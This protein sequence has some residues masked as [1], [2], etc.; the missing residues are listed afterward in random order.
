MIRILYVLW[1]G[2]AVVFLSWP[3]QAEAQI[4]VTAN[5]PR[6]ESLSQQTVSV[7]FTTTLQA[8]PLPSVIGWSVRVNTIPVTV[9]S[10][11]ILGRRANIT[12][13]ATPAHAANA[14]LIPGDVVDISY[15]D[16]IA[17][18]NTLTSASVEIGSFTNVASKNNWV[19]ACSDLAF[20]L[21]GNYAQP[22]ICSPVN[23]NFKQYQYY[24]S[25]RLRNS[26]AFTL[27]A[28]FR[29]NILWGDGTPGGSNAGYYSD[30]AGTAD[31]A[32]YSVTPGFP[33]SIATTRAT[34]VF[35][36]NTNVCSFTTTIFPFIVGVVNCNTGLL[37]QQTTFIS[38]DFDSENTGA[39]GLVPAVANSNRICLGNNVNMRFSD[40]TNLNC[41]PDVPNIGAPNNLIRWIRVVYGYQNNAGGAINNIRNVVVTGLLTGGSINV[42]NAA[43][44]ISPAGGYFPTGGGGPGIPNIPDG[45]GVIELSTPVTVATA[46]SFMQ[47]ITT[48]A[49]TGHAVGQR[50]Y[51]RLDYWNTCNQ[52]D[53]TAGS[54]ALART[55]D[56]YDEIITKP[57][58]L[59][60]AGQ[61]LC[62]T[63]PNSTAF[64]FTGA[65][66]IGAA[67]TGVNWY[68]DVASVATATRMT[69]GNGPNSLSFPAA[70]YGAQGGIGGNFTIDNADGRYM[71]V[72]ATQVAGG[73]N[74][75][76]SD[77]VE[78]VILQQPRI[79]PA[80][81]PAI[82]TGSASVCNG[83]PGTAVIYTQGTSPP[84]KPIPITFSTNAAPVNFGTENLWTHGFGAGVTPTSFVGDTNTITYNLAVQPNPSVTANVN[85]ALQYR[86]GIPDRISVISPIPAP[87]TIPT[88]FITPLA[89]T[90][91]PAF[92][93]VTVF[94]QS[95]AGVI[96]PTSQT[97]C[98]GSLITN[99][100]IPVPGMRGVIIGWE[101]SV[102]MAPFVADG[103]LGIG[104]PIAPLVPI[105][106]GIQTSYRYRAIV[107]NGPCATATSDI[108]T[109]IVNPRPVSATLAG[110]ATICQGAP[111]NLVV[112]IV[113]GT[114]PFTVTYNDGSVS[115]VVPGYV[116]GTNIPVSPL[117]TRTYTLVSVT[118][119][120]GPPAC[121]PIT[122][123]GTAIVTISNPTSAVIDGDF[124]I[125]PNTSTDFNVVITGGVGPYTLRY[126][127]GGPPVTILNYVSGAPI[128]TGSLVTSRTY[129]ITDVRDANNCLSLSNSGSAIIT[130]GSLPSAATFA[131]GGAVCL[132]GSRSLTLTIT[133]GVAPYTITVTPSSGPVINN[134]AYISGANILVPTNAVGTITYN[135]T[136]VRDACL[137]VLGAAVTGNPQ[138]VTVNNIPTS[139]NSSPAAVCSQ[140]TLN[141]DP[142]AN[143]A[144]AVPSSF[145]WTAAYPGGLTGGAASGSGIINAG[146]LV[147]LT[148]APL[149]AIFTVTPTSTVAPT[150]CVGAAFTITQVVNPQ[151]V[152]TPKTTAPVCSNVAFSFNPQTIGINGAGGNSVLSNF[153][154]IRGMLPI[155]LTEVTPGTGIGNIAETL[156][157][158]TGGPLSAVYTVTPSAATGTCLGNPFTITV[159]VNPQPVATAKTTAAV[160]SNV[161]FSFN[162][163]IVGINGAG[164][165]SVASTFSWTAFYDLGLTGG[166]ANS[167]GNVVGTL[168]N[169]TAGS[170]NAIYTVT[171]T[172]TTGTCLGNPFTIT[173]PVNAE[174]VILTQP[175]PAISCAGDVVSFTVGATGPGLTYQWQENGINLTNVGVYSGVSTSTLTL[176]GVTL[177][178]NT[179]QYRVVLTTTG[180]CTKNSNAALLTV[181]PLPVVTNRN[182][183][184]CSDV[185]GGTTRVVDL[186]ALQNAGPTGVGSGPGFAWFTDLALI[187]PIGAPASYGVTNLLP[188]YCQVTD[189]LGCISVATVTYNVRPTPFNNVIRDGTGVVTIATPGLPANYDICAST[190]SILFQTDGTSNPGSSFAWAIP[191]PT[192]AG[193]FVTITQSANI[194]VMQFPNSTAPP[195]W[196]AVTTYGIGDVVTNGTNRYRS[197]VV[198]NLNNAPASSPGQWQFLSI[199]SLYS[200]GIPITVT[201]TLNGCPGNPITMNVRVLAS[202][203]ASLI[204]GPLSVCENSLVNY[205]ASGSGTFSWGLPPGATITSLPVT[206]S[207]IT[208]QIGTFSGNVTVLNSNGICTSS[209]ATPLAVVVQ[210][211]PTLVRTINPVCSGQNV[212]IQVALMGGST[213]NWIVQSISGT[214]SGVNIGDFANSVPSINQTPINTSGLP[215]SI[216]YQVT[217]VG[218]APDF[219]TGNPQVF[220]VTVNPEPVILAA[221]SK[222]ICSGLPANFKILLTPIG[223]PVLT[224]FQWAAPVF[225]NL[226]AGVTG[227]L[228]NPTPGGQLQSDAV[229]IADVLVNTTNTPLTAIYS[230]SPING[231]CTGSPVD[232]SIIVDPKPAI[233]DR[234]IPAICSGANFN[235]SPTDGVPLPT[236]IVPV[237][238]TYE[239]TVSVFPTPG[240][241]TGALNQGPPGVGSISQTLNNTTTGVQTASYVVTPKSGSCIGSTFLITVPVEPTP[242]A[243]VSNTIPLVCNGSNVNINIT[244]GASTTGASSFDLAVSST[245]AGATGGTAFLPPLTNQ[246]YAF[247][248]T[249]TLTNSSNAL[250]TVTYTVTPRL[251]GGCSNGIP[252]VRTVNV[253][254][255]PVALVNNTTPLGCNGSNV[256]INITNGA[257]TS[258]ASTFNLTVSSTNP[259]AT[260]G[261]AFLA[262]L[263][264]ET[265]PFPITGTLT[266]SSNALITVTYIV[267]PRLAGGCANGTPV[268]TTVNV[269]PVPTMTRTLSTTS[270]ICNG[271]NVNFNLT[272][273]TAPSV[274]GDIKWD[275]TVTQTGGSGVVTGTAFANL[276][277][278]IFTAGVATLNGTLTTSGNTAATV[279]FVFTPKLNGTSNCAGVAMAPVDVVVEPTPTMTRVLTT[280]ATICNSG[281]IGFNLASLTNPSVGSDIKW[282][283][284]VTQ[285]GGAGVVTGTA[286]ANL[287]N[288]SFTAGVA[289]LSG[290]LI[291][292]GTNSATVRF[293][294]TPKLNG[295][296]NC[297]GLAM[298]PVDVVVEPT[299]TMTRT[300]TTAAAICNGGNV[301]I[302]LTTLTSSSTAS[303]IK[304]DVTVIEFTGTGSAGGTAFTNLSNQTFTAG[305]ATLNGT[306]IN[307]SSTAIIVRFVFTPKLSGTSNCAG[308]AMAPIDVVV[309]PTPTMTRTLTS[310]STICNGGNV[311]I[312]LTTP[313]APS[314]SAD[315]KWDVTVTQ[316]GGAGVVAGTAFANL[317]N[318]SFTAGAAILNGTLTNSGTNS[319]TVR[320]VFTPKLNGSSNCAGVALAP[321][322]VIV[323]PTPTMTRILTSPA[324][325]CSGDNVNIDLTTATV[326]SIPADIKWDVT[327]IEFTGTGS[328]GGTAFVN[329]TSQVFTAG[330]ANLT[331]TLTNSSNADITVR[332]IFT[333]KLSGSSTCAG[334]AMAPIDVVVEPTPVMTRTLTTAAT[335]CNGG[336]VSI[337]LAT[338]T[339]SSVPADIKW[340]VTV[341]QTTGAGVVSGTAFANLTNQNFIAAAATLAGTLTNGGNDR[342]TV[343]FVFTPKLNGT[344]V[345]AGVALAPVD[346]VVEPTP[347][348][349]A[350][351]NSPATQCNGDNVS[352]GLTT[353]TAPSVASDIK[354]DVT[355]T[356]TG[357]SGV[358]AGTAFANLTNR[359][360]SAGAAT[361]G[362]TLTNVG[363]DNA[364]VRF[365]FTPKLQGTS[366]CA[367][368]AL[369]PID[370]VVAPTPTAPP[371]TLDA[372]CSSA[373]PY[374]YDLQTIVNLGNSVPSRFTYTVTSTNPLAV[375][376]ESN[377][378]TATSTPLSHV[379]TNF[380]SSDETIT[381]VVTPFSI[382]NNCQGTNFQFKV[383]VQPE[384]VGQ[385]T[386]DNTCNLALNY[387]I[388]T[389]SIT[390]GVN[391]NFTYTVTSSN[392]VGVPPAADRLSATSANIT[393]T[394]TNLTGVP[395]FVIY[396]I[397]PRSIANDCAGSPFTYTATI[398]AEP[399]GI[400]GLTT[401]TCSDASFTIDPQ[402]RIVPFVASTFV[403]S[404]SYDGGAAVAG[405]G[406]ITALFTNQ[407]TAVK[408]AVYTVTPT[409]GTCQGLP[410]TITVPINPESV[411]T[412][413]LANPTAVCSTNP[414]NTNII[415]V[416]LST[417]AS[418]VA[419]ASYIVTL[420]SKDAALVGMPTF[421]TFP[422]IAGISNAIRNDTYQN[423][424]AVARNVVYTVVPVS[425]A[426]EFCLGDA[427]DITV[428]INPEP[429][430]AAVVTPTICSRDVNGIILGTNGS[431]VTAGTY[432]LLARTIVPAT[433]LDPP[434]DI[435]SNFP[436]VVTG[437]LVPNTTN[438]AVGDISGFNLIRNDKFINTTNA[439]ITIQY[440]IVGISPTPSSC[441]GQSQ[442]ISVII[443]PEP[444][445]APGATSQ[446]SGLATGASITLVGALGSVTP[447]QYDL[448]GV[449][450]GTL[451]PS[452]TN[453]GLGLKSTGLGF[454]TF[455]TT[456]VFT[457]T[458]SIAVPVTYTLVPIA[459]GCRG[460]AQTVTLTVNPAPALSPSLNRTVCSEESAGIGMT[461][462]GSSAPPTSYNYLSV[463]APG[464]T[465]NAA[466]VTFP[467]STNV[468]PSYIINDRYINSTNAPLTATYVI[469]P[470]AGTCVGPPVSVV[471]T[472]EP[473]VTMVTPIQLAL[474]SNSANSPSQTSFVLASLTIPTS[475]TITYDYT[476]FAT[477][478][479]SVSGF[480][481]SQGNLPNGTMITD[482]LVNNTITVATVTYVITPKAVGAR[483]GVGC[484]AAIPTT[485]VVSVEPQPRLSI[486]PATQVV[487]EGVATT[488]VL[489]STTV[490]GTGF[491]Q[492]TKPIAPVATGG[493]TLIS[494]PKAIYVS[495]EQIGDIWDN[496]TTSVQTVTYTF[497]SQIV[498]G[499]GCSSD[500]ITVLL[501]V[502]PNPTIVA[503]LQAPICSADFV[504]V[505]LTPD[506]ANTLA[507]F[508]VAAPSVISGASNGAGNLIF[509]TLFYNSATP[510]VANSNVPV[511]VNYTVTPRANNC[512][513]PSIAVPV[514][515]NPKPKILNVPTTIRVCHG[516]SLSIPLTS[517]V[518]GA[519]YTWTVDNPSGLSGIVEQTTAAPTSVNQVVT[520][521]TGVQASLTYT[522][523][524]FGPGATNCE[525]DQKIV[526]VT[527]A[528]EMSAS[529][530]N[531]PTSIC[532]GTSEF[533]IIQLN[534]QAPFN[535]VYNQNDGVTS[536][537]IPVTGAGNFRVI[538]VSPT[539]T[540]TYSIT[541]ITDAFSCDLTITGQSVVIT[542]GDPDPNFSIVGPTSQCPLPVLPVFRF[543]YNQ[544]A[545][546]Q[547]TWQWQDGSADSTYLAT[548]NVTS[549]IVQHTFSNLS[550]TRAQDYNVTMRVEL[551]A[552]FPGCF[553]FT[554]KK[555]TVFSNLLTNV[556]PDRTVICSGET[557][558]LS[559][560][561]LGVTS[562]KWF[563]RNTGTTLENEIKTSV[564]ANF[565]IANNSAL[566]PMPIQLVYQARNANC[567]A[568]DVVIDATVYK[569][570]AAAFNEGVVP[571]FNSGSATVTYTN[572]STPFD[573]FNFRYDWIF[574]IIGDATPTTLTQNTLSPISV[575]YSSPG[576]KT[577]FLSAINKVAEAAGITCKSEASKNITII[578]PPLAASFDIDPTELCF[579]GSIKLKN[580][581]GTGFVHEWRVLNQKTGA[582]FTSNV[583]DPVEFKITS[584]G[585]YTVSYRTSIPATGQVAIAPLKDVVIYD[586]PMASFDLRPDIVFV[587]DMEMSTFNF[588]SGANIY[589]WD[590]GDGTKSEEFEP[591]YTYQ[592]EGKYDVTLIAKFDHGNGVV[593][594]DTLKR[595]IIAKQGGASKIPNAFT[596]NSNGASSNGQGANGSFNDVFLPL[597]KGVANDSDAYN[598]QIYDRWGNLIFESTSSERGWDGYNRDGKLMPTG[599]YVYK[600]TV[601]FSDS[602]RTT[603][604]GDITLLR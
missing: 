49:T 231:T 342:A 434:V 588:S 351:L 253:E 341:T 453:A 370:V 447:D 223:L 30:N 435:S 305:V 450:F 277:N 542:V 500:D 377:R 534:G 316:T 353:F 202:P 390:N 379:Y 574:G 430:I 52:Y 317:T 206:A 496:P 218:P 204:T 265:Y 314:V 242:V 478:L 553:K 454:N 243:L 271:N 381:Y 165:N 80:N 2:F 419:A 552:P 505:T 222:T 464:L 83:P 472:V 401:A 100:S 32:F 511:T 274:A 413:T 405:T 45:N 336:N 249:G 24:L 4:D 261:L 236:T 64:N 291:N 402:T 519:N 145:T 504:N 8:V 180:I 266:N 97:I 532:K 42:T 387:N 11:S 79:D 135:V 601:R 73:S 591:K 425:A 526:I 333:P 540:T 598:L 155:G 468:S 292:S 294:F 508:T 310:S 498:G 311:S 531:L 596:P 585:K 458:S 36:D 60:T 68:R 256:N 268:A 26:T 361:L 173:V 494:P 174:A 533:L 17:G 563:W 216:S 537:N 322:D 191:G 105:I 437:K 157:N 211:R 343:R 13:D 423:T 455:L 439:P 558:Q 136:F 212:N 110:T 543:Q 69:N 541:S 85:V 86:T 528:P 175:T 59:T 12:F 461:T 220:A 428:L 415:N 301:N 345:C 195:A 602:Q 497:R 63:T 20:F 329:R 412:P 382:F 215:A 214:I 132:N 568:P 208:V 484:S 146:P 141:I 96:A 475:G 565:T 128:S 378:T 213:Y 431:S 584:A 78:I 576:T 111:T 380:S 154:W 161:A 595:Q 604:V 139:N 560:Q 561:S 300:L 374:T 440:T 240:S 264:N 248:I 417:T 122:L 307:S 394:Y 459:N 354:W 99:I 389:G 330:A 67:R 452:G 182:P 123:S 55:I 524:A 375:F 275:L 473:A 364:I 192:Y 252:V 522:I 308:V 306:L 71:S 144:N 40:A 288:Q 229:H 567:A 199:N 188:V 340:D 489:S 418:S 203:P 470:L 178:L 449:N 260:G 149:S 363:N 594:A 269:E 164:G 603:Q 485:L 76:E 251:A 597:V 581:I 50:F 573:V 465:A 346:V 599:V 474:C 142:S 502:N 120:A 293:L 235:V 103:T 257:T 529:F 499:L 335:I 134:G 19:G 143:I 183:I 407:S 147:N 152:A 233:F 230:I 151:P 84:T 126:N 366:N 356:Q 515:V 299:P 246:T 557:I 360:F 107:Q 462:T 384:P 466:N 348:M 492:F 289:T 408:N 112:T 168:I 441:V 359:S 302:D 404:R 326:S 512:T 393:D 41:V 148:G 184:V 332:F 186:T 323:E 273:L 138:D 14:Y 56:N 535:F 365:V 545:G 298:V 456:D 21:Q 72:W 115:T 355:V 118:D 471:L 327:V 373:T 331:G 93:P 65:S 117:I 193:E 420:K 124:N 57:I 9:N 421:G 113:G 328:A 285:T 338:A 190:S 27:A 181:N 469:S 517:N 51:V 166:V 344:S 283:V 116:S 548:T 108:A 259:G 70:Q 426:P 189:V 102:N 564:S 280:A 525:G 279:R 187:L 321:V 509:Q 396:T 58:P 201:E 483:F 29:Y 254:P 386:V 324:V 586:L 295:T 400:S 493:M 290:T 536:T 219:C 160:C 232:V 171:P 23:N 569:G 501:T 282:D 460:P 82:P 33:A 43:G 593:C 391:S 422:A 514:V 53:G 276:T 334:V 491:I 411:M 205:S 35:P 312:N 350:S 481:A 48:S 320:F 349:L 575:V 556:F 487:C 109:I 185:P 577:I 467:S 238:T 172:A 258:G 81:I 448:T 442:V 559:N 388:Q 443:N 287:T 397:T 555:V 358:V 339:I 200:A 226:P 313:T 315:I 414:S 476:A 589:S 61:A 87:F 376:P 1:V 427:F 25:L 432:R 510:T 429:V 130:V 91:A 562:H 521:T 369:A 446:C 129:F 367:G 194:L 572:T 18:S 46:T 436:V 34:K 16:A 281:N 477:P 176:T 296:S 137:A 170:L 457:N 28:R 463:S 121:T 590:F 114:S 22:D 77:P 579:P 385:S 272:T 516:N 549:Q 210:L 75:C 513:G 583:A 10:I 433:L 162:P 106:G 263:T 539:T 179:R 347:T 566:N 438:V 245:N 89:C 6:H 198:G 538:Q 131:G 140:T 197:L 578:L 217:P 551:P 451:I 125:C 398:N 488:M 507:T 506:V 527:V 278:Q 163:Q 372:T 90:T 284:A 571:P 570:V 399:V 207:T 239:W 250:I 554:S 304:W 518:T 104:N 38:Y 227:A 392:A 44:V 234:V 270:T 224:K 158:L 74:T 319:A 225:P 167:T 39:L 150:L 318:Q 94:G 221:Q 544:R 7:L 255:T 325:Q 54:L 92:L 352:I 546:T 547:Y 156:Q 267:T 66:S 486:T 580:V 482:K 520:N 503:S 490:P 600:L 5:D 262:P 88:Y 368:A 98:E 406:I 309:E 244:N 416:V 133:G 587:P 31:A 62:F 383:V 209:P 479:N 237:G 410:F 127:F 303:D 119:A 101:R 592:I 424:T 37:L 95:N 286:F 15:N 169:L 444:I 3:N 159:P 495:G 241:L 395:V 582:S 371:I 523:K 337:S 153:T 228:G 196:S 297:A 247:P 530:Q 550:P 362:G 445:L 357:G 480:F 403:W 409:A 47:T 177:P